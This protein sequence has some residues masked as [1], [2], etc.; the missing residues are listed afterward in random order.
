LQTET[1]E[2]YHVENGDE[3]LTGNSKVGLLDEI[4]R[5]YL[6]TV[7]AQIELEAAL[8]ATPARTGFL[9]VRRF[10]PS[11]TALYL[12]TKTVF[13]DQD[14][15]RRPDLDGLLHDIEQWRQTIISGKVTKEEVTE[16]IA[17]SNRY[18]SECIIKDII[19]VAQ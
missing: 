19:K 3:R 12:L 1:Y 2:N 16:G 8:I 7:S 14:R 11:F 15:K 17:L 6:A 5:A 10:F 4:E 9:F 18:C 13:R